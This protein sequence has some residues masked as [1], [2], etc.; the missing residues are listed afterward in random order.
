MKQYGTV[1][2]LTQGKATLQIPRST[3]CGDK[4]GSCSS[5]CKQEKIEIDVK[6][7]L[8]AVVGDR[9][10]VESETKTILG[11][12]FLVYIVPVVMLFVGMIVANMI[13]NSMGILLNEFVSLLIG[14]VFM[15]ITFLGIRLYDRQHSK[16]QIEIFT[17]IRR[18]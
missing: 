15:A 13:A 2:E 14:V 5:H 17:M 18:M 16:K 4:C 7:R 8:N 9:V 1:V 3:A 12:A 10:E 6:N 11:A